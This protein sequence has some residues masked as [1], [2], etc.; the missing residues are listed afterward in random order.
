M[1]NNELVFFGDEEDILKEI[2]FCWR[3]G[4]RFAKI[5]EH[6]NS[7]GYGYRITPQIISKCFHKIYDS[8]GLAKYQ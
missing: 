4:F 8:G 2:A 7:K 3:K 5:K 6:L 1:E